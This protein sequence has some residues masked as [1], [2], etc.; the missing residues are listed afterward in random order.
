MHHA[1]ACL[2]LC[3][4]WQAFSFIQLNYFMSVR[5]YTFFLICMYI[6]AV[7]LAANVGLCVWVANSFK[8]NSF[9][10]VW[11]VHR[12]AYAATC[13]LLC[14]KTHTTGCTTPAAGPSCG[15]ATSRWCSTKC[16][17]WPA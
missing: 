7:A 10:H 4:W 6:L 14:A 1:N 2:A 13:T 15:C 3:R 16:W 9:N 8:N 17:T 5:G 12:R 11:C